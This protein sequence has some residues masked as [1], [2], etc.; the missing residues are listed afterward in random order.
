M[1]GAASFV[2]GLDAGTSVIKAALFDRGLRCRAVAAEP[3]PVSQPHPDWSEADPDELW[4]RACRVIRQAM[5]KAEV[6]PSAVEGVGVSGCMVGAWVIG[7]DDGTVR[8]GIL[9]N[10]GRTQGMIEERLAD[11]PAFMSRIFA[12]SGSVMQQGCTLPLMAWLG[13]HEP[14]VL[15]AA[16]AVV[17]CKDW[18]RWRLTGKVATDPSEASVAPGDARGRGRCEA[19]ID[20]LGVREW[21][22]LLPEPLPSD[23]V[24]GRVTRTAADATGLAL[25]TP[26]VTGA[27]DVAASVL[28]A[29]AAA[30]GTACVILGTTC[31]IGTTLERPSFTPPDLGLLFCLPDGGWWR[32]MVNIAGTS[33]LDWVL[34]TLGS[35]T[36][37]GAEALAGEV[38]P[39]AD[40]LLYLP[41]LSRVGIIAPF[42]EPRA[43]GAFEGLEPRHGRAHLLRAV[44]EGVACSIRDGFDVIGEPVREVRLLGG[45]ARSALWAQIVTDC[46][47][48]PV[49]AMPDVEPGA[50]G[51]AALAAAGIGWFEDAASAVSHHPPEVRRFEPEPARVAAYRRRHER[52]RRLA[53]TMRRHWRE[54]TQ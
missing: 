27:G 22:H 50:R 39:G 42:V 46:V 21:R 4:R 38:P 6:A 31:L 11:D 32:A 37:D 24:A 54:A 30:P 23:A 19:M 28:G 34:S 35:I 33:N 41:Y 29:G 1:A 36:F 18:L 26:V 44:Y 40:G 48:R 8:P 51:A 43:R 20:L 25:G 14:E 49:V 17:G 10:D 2:L 15:A 47:D 9:W 12:R 3:M 16:G 52:Y 5:A 7:R 45:G 53:R 13:E